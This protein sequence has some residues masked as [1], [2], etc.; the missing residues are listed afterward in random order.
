MCIPFV[1]TQ[2]LWLGSYFFNIGKLHNYSKFAHISIIKLFF[3]KVLL[4]PL[5]ETLLF[6][7]II[8]EFFLLIFKGN[9]VIIALIIS[10]SV[11]GYS[12]YFNTQNVL[13]SLFAALIGLIFASIY[14]LTKRRKD[15]NPFL[16]VFFVH[17]SINLFAFVINDL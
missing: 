8:I 17:L 15:I 11:F 5:I 13:Y 10:A 7:F 4:A 6:Q 16:L 12:H 2:L 1:Y 14:I 3:Y 9:K